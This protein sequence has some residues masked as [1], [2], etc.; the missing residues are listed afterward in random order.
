VTEYIDGQTLTQWMIDN[1]TPT[2]ETVREIA[3]QIA[4]GLLALHRQEMIHQD[5]RPDNIM[6]DSTGTVKIIDF[7]S[8]RIKGIIESNAYLEQENMLGTA[9][10]SAPEYFL[11]EV[12][13]YR[14]DLFSLGVIVYQMISG[15]LPYGTQ[16]ARSTTK[17]AQKKLKYKHLNSHT[18]EVPIWVDETLKK[19]LEPNPYKRYAQ[20]SEFLF[21][22][23]HPNKAFL[24]KSR[25]PLLE[26]NPVLLWKTVSLVLAIIIVI[27][28]NK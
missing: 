13:S 20:L 26:R 11:G 22:L 18:H 9:Q 15:D 16:V 1:P 27:L 10:Y 28:L 3:E 4:R 23:R 6:I 7:G 25:P 8:T 24:N 19:A 12:G 21:D 2:L 5:L 17:A 14:S